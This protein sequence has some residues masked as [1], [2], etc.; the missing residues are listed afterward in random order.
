MNPTIETR[1]HGIGEWEFAWKLKTRLTNI[2]PY[3]DY[4]YLLGSVEMLL[5]FASNRAVR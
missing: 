5:Y 3:M 1:Y 2:L 4:F